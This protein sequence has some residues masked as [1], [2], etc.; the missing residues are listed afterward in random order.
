MRCYSLL[1]NIRV[2]VKRS[3]VHQTVQ[4]NSLNVINKFTLE[5]QQLA[6]GVVLLV[7]PR[8]KIMKYVP[9]LNTFLAIVKT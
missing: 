9:I 8:T 4:K 7:A 3:N 1:Q 6:I 2:R 5:K